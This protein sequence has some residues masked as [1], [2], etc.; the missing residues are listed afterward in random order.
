MLET[1]MINGS[2]WCIKNKELLYTDETGEY[3][4]FKMVIGFTEPL[5]DR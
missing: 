2:S 5:I 3:A 4:L 1:A